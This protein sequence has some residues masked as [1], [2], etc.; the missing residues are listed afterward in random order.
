MTTWRL[1]ISFIFV[2][3]RISK[4]PKPKEI[5]DKKQ[6]HKIHDQTQSPD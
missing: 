4:H 1:F 6:K 2:L 5:P 3:E